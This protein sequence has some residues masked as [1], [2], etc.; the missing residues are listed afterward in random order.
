MKYQHEKDR[1]DTLAIL[2]AYEDST[3]TAAS[4]ANNLGVSVRTLF[5]MMKRLQL[6]MRKLRKLK[7]GNDGNKDRR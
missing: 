4:V 2:Q 7:K 6:S 5:L 1:L 3:G